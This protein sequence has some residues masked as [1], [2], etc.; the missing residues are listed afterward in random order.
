MLLEALYSLMANWILLFMSLIAFLVFGRLLLTIDKDFRSRQDPSVIDLE[1]AYKKDAFTAILKTWTKSK[2]DT[3]V[4][5]FRRQLWYDNLWAI[6]YAVLFSSFIAVLTIPHDQ[7]P[8][9]LLLLL[10]ALPLLAA[11]FDIFPENTLTLLLLRRVRSHAD[12]DALP[13]APIWVASIAARIKF[14][15]LIAA[16][17]GV[18]LFLLIKIV[19]FL[20]S[21]QSLYTS[22]SS[23]LL[24]VIALMT[25][26]LYM[27]VLFPQASRL[28]RDKADPDIVALQLAF[29]KARFTKVLRA[30]HKGRGSAAIPMFRKSV[31]Q[32][33]FLFPIIYAV[34]FASAIATITS[35]PIR[36]PEQVELMLF[37]LPF[38]AAIFDWIENGLHLKILKGVDSWVEIEAVNPTLIFLASLAASIKLALLLIS[39][40]AILVLLVIS[41]R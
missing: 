36:K 14:G 20:P 40:F 9:T 13:A 1:M 24:V 22:M 5:T 23:W 37:L 4:P 16:F 34:F 35:S 8:G 31:K 30:W 17:A 2:G 41:L 10:F 7:A 28:Y 15:L 38:L 6:T 29:T 25:S 18:I 3:A 33:D 19:T 12:I 39:S 11:I 21:L 27:R 32:L 26:L